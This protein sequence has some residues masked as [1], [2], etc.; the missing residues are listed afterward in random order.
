MNLVKN[1]VETAIE[2]EARLSDTAFELSDGEMLTLAA[3]IEGHRLFAEANVLRTPVPAPAALE[4]IAMAL[5]D[6]AANQ[7]T[8]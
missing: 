8:G 5:K 4:A 7:M 1:V 3:T 6:V 2:L